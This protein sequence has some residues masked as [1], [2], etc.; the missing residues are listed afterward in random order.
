MKKLLLI[1][2]WRSKLCII[3]FLVISIQITN[4]QTPVKGNVKNDNGE[5]LSGVSVKVKNNTQGVIT[6]LNGSFTLSA[7]TNSVL[8]FSNIGY[9]TKEIIVTD[10][11][12]SIL[13]T[14][15]PEI[16]K[17]N[18][19]IVQGYGGLKRRDITGS[20]SG[21]SAAV[22]SET[23]ATTLENAMQGRMAG[24]NITNTSAEPGGGIDIQV[25]GITSISGGNQ[26]L[27]VIDGVPQYNDDTRSAGE[28][29]GN[30]PTNFLATLNPSDIESVEVLKDAS[31]A[32]IY[33]SRGANGVII[34]TTKKGKAGRPAIDFNYYETLAQRPKEIPLANAQQ[35]ATFINLTDT[36]DGQ[37]PYYDGTYK[38]T[39]NNLDSIYFPSP[40]QLGK[41]TDWQHVIYRNA[42]TENAQLTISGG[43]ENIKYLVSGNYLEDEGVVVYS[44][45][46]KG[47]LRGSLDAK[48]NDHFSTSLSINLAQDLNNRAENSN[49]STTPG[50]LSPSGTILKSFL[51]SPV[52]GPDDDKYGAS[53]LLS[54]R[55][56]SSG[57]INPLY[58][59]EYSINQR[60]SSYSQA[61]LDLVYKFND[62]FNLTVRGG[63]NNTQSNNDQYWGL[64]TEQGYD[65]GQQ[66]F[67]STWNTS[68]YINE[69]FLTFNKSVGKFHSNVVVGV[70]AE[71]DDSRGTTLSANQLPIPTDNGL[72]LLPLYK[73]IN[74]PVTNEIQSTLL[75]AFGRAS[76]DYDNKYLL[77]LSARDDGSSKFAANKKYAFFPSIGLGWNFSEEDFFKNIQN[78]LSNGKLRASF[79]TS[80]NQAIT[81][82][83]SL[84]S[85]SPI[86]YGFYNG[87]ATGII[88]N[89]SQNDN[90]TWETT[91]QIDLGLELGF[92][93]NRYRFSFDLY[94]K[95]TDN[96]LQEED[97]PS[98]S[99]YTSILANFGSI[100]N[101]GAE[102][103]LGATIIKNNSFSWNTDFNI[104]A[105]RN[106]I[107]SLGPGIDYYN[108][109]S[110]QADYT[111][112]LTVGGSIGEFWGYK[113]NGL[114]T[115]QDIANKYPTLG[116]STSEGD[117]KFVDNNHDGVINDA[118]KVGL[119]NALP[120]FTAGLSN[121]FT[122]HNWSLNIFLNGVFGNQ[123]LNQNL[124]YSEYGSY[125]GVPSQKYLSNYW[126]PQ[127]PNAYYPRPSAAAVN[128][129]T[130]D[131]LIESGTYVRIKTVTLKYNLTNIPKWAHKIQF[132]LTAN[133]LY[134]FTKYDGYDPEVSA[135]GQNVLTPGI[136]VG[137]YP[138]TRMWTVGIDLGL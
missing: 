78:I 70:S 16:N 56:S 89:T 86:S 100:R 71:K 20:S 134:T 5:A 135:Y 7:G 31:S 95:T 58:D 94:R 40:S 88:T 116:G 121:D 12:K 109:T 68:T 120:H 24:V 87:E 47:S 63:Y 29:N 125:F 59:L 126:T 82:Y 3:I 111:H 99:G 101:Q 28:T 137:S 138:R 18:E 83:Q 46:K 57:L 103:E 37:A 130:S 119:G 65:N 74:L 123:I 41:G 131:R 104:S 69:D 91:K 52:L 96:L 27:Y 49:L 136:D 36:N 80:G 54:D 97:I 90:L 17:L 53:L 106:K 76:L 23:P 26:P 22:I 2:L 42:L 122:Y 62:S 1:R 48:I 105:N 107:L 14:L 81:A 33:G 61:T 72:Y 32:S 133:N 66:T 117:L 124:L 108:E 21:I 118:D 67:Q 98:E 35:F 45:Y 132:Y 55:G 114:L 13:V 112:R 129:V 6:D 73:N 25:R 50:G 113:T 75:S 128:N 38:K 19:V 4:A 34:I 60:S 11:T 93:Q 9:E 10:P 15:S 30:V 84:A 102:L 77:T 115:A 43:T 85:L 110:G 51:A 64:Q 8:I 44:K 127:N 39:N 92:L 79:G